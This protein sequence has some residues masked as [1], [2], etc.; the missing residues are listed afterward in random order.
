MNVKEAMDVFG[1]A[2]SE[3]LAVVEDAQSRKVVG[4]LNE[5]HATRRYAEALNNASRDVVGEG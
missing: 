4:L 5:S 1:K 2:E 3:V